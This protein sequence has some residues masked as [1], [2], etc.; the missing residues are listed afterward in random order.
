[1]RQGKFDLNHLKRKR[2][3]VQQELTEVAEYFGMDTNKSKPI[4]VFS[5]IRQFIKDLTTANDN[6]TKKALSRKNSSRAMMRSFSTPT[7]KRSSRNSSFRGSRN[8]SAKSSRNSSARSS[9]RRAYRSVSVA[10]AGSDVQDEKVVE[11]STVSDQRNLSSESSS[12]YL[13]RSYS[14]NG[15][16][17]SHY[18]SS[19]TTEHDNVFDCKKEEKEWPKEPDLLKYRSLMREYEERQKAKRAN[20]ERKEEISRGRGE[21]KEEGGEDQKLRKVFLSPVKEKIEARRLFEI[22]KSGVSEPEKDLKIENRLKEGETICHE[23]KDSFERELE[24][25]EAK[26]MSFI[27]ANTRKHSNEIGGKRVADKRIKVNGH[28]DDTCGTDRLANESPHDKGL[29]VMQSEI[30]NQECNM[31]SKERPKEL[32]T[33][34][35]RAKNTFERENNCGQEANEMKRSKR[36]ERE[37]AEGDEIAGEKERRDFT[38]AADLKVWKRKKEKTAREKQTELVYYDDYYNVNLKRHSTH[39]TNSK[40]N[41]ENGQRITKDYGGNWKDED[42]T[43]KEATMTG[44]SERNADA[45]ISRK[46]S[47]GKSNFVRGSTRGSVSRSRSSSRNSFK[48][49]R[50]VKRVNVKA[51]QARDIART[52]T[53][54][55]SRSESN[56]GSTKSQRRRTRSEGIQ[57][58]ILKPGFIA[59]N[60]PMKLDLTKKGNENKTRGKEK[61]LNI[62]KERK[63]AHSEPTETSM[64]AKDCNNNEEGLEE[65]KGRV[66]G[67]D[68]FVE[69]GFELKENQGP[70]LRR[71]KSAV[72]QRNVREAKLIFYL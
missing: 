57:A 40:K 9:M 72:I 39:V 19:R 23:R 8:S 24:I 51:L 30:S 36:S 34:H 27:D 16:P 3:Q 55:S 14:E 53:M 17:K 5:T 7:F 66:N 29:L 35:Y 68:P 37:F 43:D 10:S 63:V 52:M 48:N 62:D 47:N 2:R 44:R 61:D 6:L 46:L 28:R 50:G 11:T 54:P 64:K 65:D 26:I 49:E 12:F 42:R 71:T 69:E 4:E 15:T 32:R 38:D 18:R 70:V 67:C 13:G 58:V 41:T 33:L 25:K 45:K 20:E 59:K 21:D 22:S 1:M 31:S 60:V 56:F